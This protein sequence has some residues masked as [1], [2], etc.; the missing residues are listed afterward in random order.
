LGINCEENDISHS[1]NESMYSDG[2]IG[3]GAARSESVPLL[4]SDLAKGKD[5]GRQERKEALL[6][7]FLSGPPRSL[8]SLTCRCWLLKAVTEPDDMSRSLS[9][10]NAFRTLRVSSHLKQP[11][12]SWLFPPY[13]PDLLFWRRCW[14]CCVPP[15]TPPTTAPLA[16]LP[17]SGSDCGTGCRTLSPTVGVLLFLLA[18]RFLLGLRLLLGGSRRWWRPGTSRL[19]LP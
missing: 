16:A 5:G 1:L 7:R 12:R 13:L 11:A 9:R 15:I 19:C 14:R 4:R 18:L 10:A 8:F 2:R 6:E 17:V 3:L